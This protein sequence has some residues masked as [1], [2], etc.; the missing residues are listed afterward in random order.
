MRTLERDGVRLAYTESG[1]GEPPVVLLHGMACRHDH[2][3]P[4]LSHLESRHRCL[5][6]DLRGHGASDAPVDAYGMDEFVADL[7]TAVDALAPARPI[8]IGHSF[9]GSIAL[10]YADRHP[11]RVG[12][13]VMLD[14]GMRSNQVLTADLGPFYTELRSGDD[15]RY[16][17]TLTQFVRDRLV[18]PVDGGAFAGEIAEL[19]CSVP[20]H[21]FL[22]MSDTVQQL[23][24]AEM[25]ARCTLPALL[26]LSRQDFAEPAAVAALGP[27]WHVGRVVGA[28][29]FVQVV[30]PAQVNAMIDRF[31]ELTGLSAPHATFPT[32]DGDPS[33]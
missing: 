20:P 24:S 30:A 22:S 16:R 15:E 4:V 6:F 11:E 28:G 19:M 27:N 14:S 13:L 9:G 29:H 7:A 3:L 31:L 26:V 21:V 5:A 23:R 33:A 10:A 32:S 17:A 12:A 1:A 8:L 18:D 2:M 25:A